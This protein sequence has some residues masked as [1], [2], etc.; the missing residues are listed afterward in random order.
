VPLALDV[1]EP[2]LQV[3]AATSARIALARA[4]A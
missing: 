1:G 2:A 4:H 3:S